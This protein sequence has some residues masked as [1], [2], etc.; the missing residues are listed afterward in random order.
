M[1]T[2]RGRVAT[3]KSYEHLGLDQSEIST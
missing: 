3:L 1:R 2:T